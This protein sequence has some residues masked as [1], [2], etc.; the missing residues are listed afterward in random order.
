[1]ASEVGYLN[2]SSRGGKAEQ[3]TCGRDFRRSPREQGGART[4]FLGLQVLGGL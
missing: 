1:M 3:V 4:H 2:L